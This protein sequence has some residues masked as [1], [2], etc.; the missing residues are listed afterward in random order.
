MRIA[1]LGAGMMAQA[2]VDAAAKRDVTVAFFGHDNFDIRDLDSIV[3]VLKPIMPDVL[4]NTVA[5]HALQRCEDD[6]DLAFAINAKGAGRVAMLA[7][8]VY[9][10][11]DYVYND[12]GP[13]PEG[14]PGR[15]P[16]SV[17][18]RSK[19][20][21]ELETLEQGGIVVRL[22]G[23]YDAI[24]QSH[25]GPSFPSQVLSDHAAIKVASDQRFSPTYAPDAAER[26]V[27]LALGGTDGFWS[28][29]IYH[30]A[31]DGSTTWAEFAQHICEVT[32]HD[33]PIIPVAKHDPIRPTDSS[34]VSTRIPPL[35]HWKQALAAWSLAR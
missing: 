12:G 10:S 26:I 24:Y 29:G 35:R 5:L 32:G 28:S 19:L 13:H 6:P 27:D 31:N 23:V 11:T 1:V 34:L 25:K 4:V 33:R 14:M 30:A 9:L 15:T 21:G 3:R 22:S 16:R 17:Y 20:A 2:V 18:G 8:T 7:P